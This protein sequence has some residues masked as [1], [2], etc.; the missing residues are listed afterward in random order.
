[1]TEKR[2]VNKFNFKFE[3]N[4]ELPLLNNKKVNELYYNISREEYFKKA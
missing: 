4:R 2:E 1:M 3:K